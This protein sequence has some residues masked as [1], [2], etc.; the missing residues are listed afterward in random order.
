M[1]LT[2]DKKLASNSTKI[3]NKLETYDIYI[4][5]VFL[6]GSQVGQL[7]GTIKTKIERDTQF[8][9]IPNRKLYILYKIENQSLW[10]PFC[11]V[12]P[13]PLLLHYGPLV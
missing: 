12:G 6:I 9:G 7:I 8:K 2:N 5:K 1:G 13:Q 4:Y 11:T 10:G 3:K